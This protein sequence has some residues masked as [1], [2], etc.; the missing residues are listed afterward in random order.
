MAVLMDVKGNVLCITINRPEVM[1]ALDP[2]TTEQ[3][4]KA[5]IEFRDNP[6]LRVC[7]LTGAGDK[8]FCAGADMVSTIG[9]AVS[10]RTTTNA[11]TDT[12]GLNYSYYGLNIWKPMIAAINGHCLA[13]GLGLALMCDIR[14][15][16]E[17]ATFGLP[18]VTLGIIPG[19]GGTQRLGR[20]ISQAKASEM[21]LMAQ[22]ID[23]QEAL[24][25][26]LINT[27]RSRQP[28]LKNTTRNN[29]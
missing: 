20:A 2:E 10:E 21:L 16:S 13:G 22:R 1:N 4:K 27:V 15:C 19:W 23:A 28:T 12:T 3:L 18:E 14:I 24:R 26:G 6:E 9:K 29:N 8:A 25:I 11:R 5:L 7:I 17:N